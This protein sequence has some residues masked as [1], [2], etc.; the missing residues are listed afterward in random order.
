M[1]ENSW[2]VHSTADS[3]ILKT[4]VDE[5]NE[6][7][8][9]GAGINLDPEYQRDYKFTNEDE[10]LLIESLLMDIPIPV[11]YLS[12]DIR[13]QPYVANVID[14]QH[15]LRAI[16]RFLNNQ[17]PLKGLNFYPEYNDLKFKEL[18]QEIQNK[19]LYQSKLNFE[20]IHV[21]DNPKIE[22]EIFKRYNKGT[23]PLS[24]QELRNAIYLSD[25]NV[26]LNEEIKAY[27]MNDPA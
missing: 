14:G 15:R 22:I 24:K 1:K 5:I 7:L 27:F 9:G 25:F 8:E 11:I 18:P 20:N 21:Q 3:K 12:S 17:F 23:H 13:K 6:A 19:L 2:A 10:S 4:I 26:W 16:Y